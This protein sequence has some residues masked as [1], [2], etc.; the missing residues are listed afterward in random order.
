MIVLCAGALLKG[1][2]ASLSP[3]YVEVDG[4]W[5]LLPEKLQRQAASAMRD[6]PHRLSP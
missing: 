4:K 2:C 3:R 5:R 1:R 6:L